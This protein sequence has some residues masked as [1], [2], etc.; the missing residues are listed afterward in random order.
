MRRRQAEPN[1]ETTRLAE[2]GTL[3]EVH[4]EVNSHRKAM[5]GRD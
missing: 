2:F 5:R 3:R 1:A 4:G